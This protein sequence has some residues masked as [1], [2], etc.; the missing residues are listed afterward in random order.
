MTN[1]G[2]LGI[3]L[4]ISTNPAVDPGF[5][6]LTTGFL[7]DASGN[8]FGPAQT[9][10]RS[11]SSDGSFSID[12]VDFTGP[13]TTV[14]LSGLHFDTSFPTSGHTITNTTLRFTLN[15]ENNVRFG[16]I[17]QLP[18]PSSLA[19]LAMGF[20]GL[21]CVGRRARSSKDQG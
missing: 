12:L 3:G 2:I 10:G 4:T 14:N 17:Q 8:Q 15:N 7:R 6:G 9:A 5:A 11:S 20:V 19:L 18:E 13:S 16:T 21:V 1:P